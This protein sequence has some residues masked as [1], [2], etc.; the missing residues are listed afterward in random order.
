[1]DKAV[2][3]LLFLLLFLYVHSTHVAF[4]WTPTHHYLLSLPVNLPVMLLEPSKPK[5][6]ILLPEVSDCE[7][8]AFR[9]SIIPED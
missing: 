7:Q 2:H 6:D 3:P 8:H 4:V 9:V 5:D 1:M